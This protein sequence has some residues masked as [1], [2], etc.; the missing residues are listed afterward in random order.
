MPKP[1]WLREL[2]RKPRRVYH[3]C[4]NCIHAGDPCGLTNNLGKGIGRV[5]MYQCKIHPTVKFYFKTYACEDY[6]Q[7]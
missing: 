7:K 4:I 5:K 3:M 2:E 6:K 1:E